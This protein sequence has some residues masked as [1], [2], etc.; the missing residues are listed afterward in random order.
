[1]DLRSL[2][3]FVEVVRRGSFSE[4]SKVLSVTQSTVSKA[5]KKLEDDTGL[6]LVMRSGHRNRLTSAGAIVYD[7]AIK[8][9]AVRAGLVAELDEL[10]GLKRGALRLGLPPVGS[11][12]LFANVLATYLQRYPGI[13][14][15]LVEHGGERLQE[16]LLSGEIELAATLIPVPKH[17][18]MLPVRDEP[19]VALLRSDHPLAGQEALDLSALKSVP[20]ILFETGV[21]LNRLI[22]EACDRSGFAPVVAARSA[23]VEFVIELAASGLGVA[24]LPQFIVERRPSAAVTAI[25]INDSQIRWRIGFIWKHDA[26]MSHAAKAWLNLVRE[27]LTIDG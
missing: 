21:G 7:A 13:D 20:F 10:R 17:F 19:I 25:L 22:V 12:T 24:F 4:A 18:D 11:S 27:T 9:L 26:F 5:V 3:A 15:T 16:I 8:M 23:Q 14:V 1:M 2:Q 6:P